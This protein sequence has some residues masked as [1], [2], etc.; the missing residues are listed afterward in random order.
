MLHKNYREFMEENIIYVFSNLLYF[1]REVSYQ[2][3]SRLT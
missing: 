3:T 2:L 1:K